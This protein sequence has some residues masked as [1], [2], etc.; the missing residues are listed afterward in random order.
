MKEIF[1]YD[2]RGKRVR[3]LGKCMSK[4][5]IAYHIDNFKPYRCAT[6]TCDVESYT[7]LANELLGCL[8]DKSGFSFEDLKTFNI[9]L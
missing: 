8:L 6:I 2:F 3:F 4:F 7:E 5:A 9:V 1:N